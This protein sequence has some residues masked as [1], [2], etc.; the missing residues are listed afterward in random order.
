MFVTAANAACAAENHSVGEFFRAVYR[1]RNVE[2]NGVDT[3]LMLLSPRT[4]QRYVRT[5]APF[6]S[7]A[8]YAGSRF[9]SAAGFESFNGVLSAVSVVPALP[10]VATFTVT[11]RLTVSNFAG[12]PGC[13]ATIAGSLTNRP[14][15]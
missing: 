8:S 4:A 3:R 9:T 7:G 15:L 11:V 1:P 6:V 14:D 12:L 13:T 2:D 10:T 5:N